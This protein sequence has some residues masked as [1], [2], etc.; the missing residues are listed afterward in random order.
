[1]LL[2][3][4]TGIQLNKE[5]SNILGHMC[6]A[7]SK[8]W[9]ECN[10]ERRNYKELGLAEYPDW[11]FQ[12]KAH[13]DSMWYRSLP[14]QTAQ[15]VCKLLDK[16]WKSFYKLLKTGGIE[17]PNPPRFKQ[18][19]M[20]VTYMQNGIV[21][22]RES[23]TVRLSL[24]KQLKAHM[25]EVYGIHENYL[26][27]ENGIFGGMETIK[28]IKLYPPGADGSVRLI[29]IYEIPDVTVLPDNGKY[30]SVDLGLHN[31]M[32]CLDSTGGSFIIGRR[33]LSICQ[34]Y[35]REIARIQSQ[36]GRQQ[37]A[38]GVKYPKTSKHLKMLHEKKHNCVRDYLHKMTHFIA[39]Y[40]KNNDIHTVVMGD[41]TGIRKDNDL[42]AVTNQK[43]HQLPYAVIYQMLEY[44]LKMRGITPV[45]QNEAWTSQCSPLS[46][47]VSGENA[48][49]KNRVERGLY[50]EG[51][52]VWNADAVG[53]Y[54]ILRKYKGS[55]DVS[56][57]KTL[58]SPKVVKVAV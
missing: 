34:K 3:R 44:K 4:E 47:T 7:A 2:S 16:G 56:E 25:A 48:Q 38:K 57:A 8:L 17:N 20:A 21:H 12:K 46:G 41:I 50:S 18:E 35:D 32:T 1:M 52:N 22:D 29:A 6:Y 9:N 10:Y 19:G 58:S 40:C 53:A 37:S 51:G 5:Q 15:E 39:E 49:K 26:F 55:T 23:N 45:R 31:L 54:N 24:P 13:K 33:Y 28:Q 14:S 42:G 30:L 36:W 43:L 27:V 11:Y